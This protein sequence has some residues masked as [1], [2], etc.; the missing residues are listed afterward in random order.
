MDQAESFFQT[1]RYLFKWLMVL[2]PLLRNRLSFPPVPMD[3]RV[4]T[5]CRIIGDRMTAKLTMKELCQN[6]IL[7]ESQMRVLFKK[8]LNVSPMEYLREVRLKKAKPALKA[9]HT[10]S[11]SITI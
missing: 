10:M 5:V 8:T 1:K 11:M 2:F 6:V 7:S 3:V 9:I 4:Q